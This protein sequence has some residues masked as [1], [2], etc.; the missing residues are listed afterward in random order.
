MIDIN[1]VMLITTITRLVIAQ[2]FA[3][4]NSVLC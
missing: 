1:Q 3:L 4:T 2:F